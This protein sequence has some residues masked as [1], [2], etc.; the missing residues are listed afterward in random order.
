MRQ[1]DLPPYCMWPKA[2]CHAT[3]TEHLPEGASFCLEH[4]KAWALEMHALL[5]RA[6]R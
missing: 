3:P 1:K 2:T 4:F 5:E 6:T